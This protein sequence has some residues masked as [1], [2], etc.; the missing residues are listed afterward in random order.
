[1]KQIKYKNI[2]KYHNVMRGSTHLVPICVYLFTNRTPCFPN[3]STFKHNFGCSV[4]RK[5][6]HIET[7]VKGGFQVFWLQFSSCGSLCS[8]HFLRLVLVNFAL[9]LIFYRTG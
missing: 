4:D 9:V 3:I 1:M 6:N 7:T 5:A 8:Q 2:L